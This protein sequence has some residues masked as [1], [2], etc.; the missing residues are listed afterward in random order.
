MSET[1]ESLCLTGAVVVPG[2]SQDVIHDPGEVWVRDGVIEAV[3][4]PSSHPPRPGERV[5]RIALGG[6]VIIPG[7]VN[8][9]SHSYG[10]LLKGSVDG[11]PLDVY[12]LDVIAASGDRSPREVYVS[13]LVD[14]IAM[15]RSGTT[16][17]IDHFSHRPEMTSEAIAAALQAYADS[18]MR[19]AVAPMYSDLPYVETLP[20]AGTQ[21]PDRVRGLYGRGRADPRRYFQAVDEVRRVLPRFGD[22]VRL[23][24]GVDGP[25]RCSPEL[26]EMT[27][28]FQRTHGMGLHTHLLESKTQAALAP[29]EGFVRWML[30]RGLLNSESSL[31][32]F[33]WCSDA[34]I[35]AAREAGVTV[36][37]VPGSNLQLGSGIAPVLR[38]FGAGVPVA[39]GSDGSNCSAPN[40]FE[41]VRLGCLLARVT[42]PDFERWVPAGAFFRGALLGGARALGEPGRVGELKPGAHADFVVLDARSASYRPRG[43]LW[44]HLVHYETGANVETVYVAGR[45]IVQG[46]R[47]H[48]LDEEAVL[49]EAEEIVARRGIATGVSRFRQEQYALF[50]DVIRT[51]LE[52]EDRLDRLARLR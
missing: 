11:V 2:G 16:A 6:K 32:H 21:V 7:L 50:R 46:G 15:L 22:R 48:T 13:T 29:P 49:A 28:D 25:Q 5:E 9:H 18:G 39:V 10:A 19:A 23:L 8:A 37:H 47:V 35:E 30:H 17:V 52:K 42:E 12:M 3:G 24:L 26:M 51:T 36:V 27:A 41:K 38:L 33:I 43:G 20:L 40:L 44:N 14:C 34:D 1:Q 45:P 31:V 4:P